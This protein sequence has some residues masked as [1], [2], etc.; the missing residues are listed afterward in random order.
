MLYI[1][2]LFAYDILLPPNDPLQQLY[3]LYW[4]HSVL[5]PIYSVFDNKYDFDTMYRDNRRE[6]YFCL[7]SYDSV[8]PRMKSQNKHKLIELLD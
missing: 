5:K 1:D 7:F 6:I 4:N 8:K 3:L 2:V